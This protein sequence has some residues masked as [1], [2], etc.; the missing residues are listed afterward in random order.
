MVV[1]GEHM[2]G[3]KIDHRGNRLSPELFLLPPGPALRTELNQV[4]GPDKRGEHMAECKQ[5][6][7][8]IAH[9]TLG[10]NL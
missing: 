7:C 6:V 4:I 9:R 5:E 10:G 3:H 8:Q 1:V 2:Q